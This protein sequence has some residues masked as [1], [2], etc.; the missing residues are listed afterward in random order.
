MNAV[1][2][3]LLDNPVL[4]LLKKLWRYS[5][6]H[7]KTVV[8]YFF[9]FVLGNLVILL[10]PI[11]VAKILNTIQEQGVNA[12]NLSSILGLIA[13]FIAI[14]VAFWVFHGPARVMETQ[15]AFHVRAA[16]KQYLL[17][18]VMRLPSSWHTD[19][20]SGDT[21]DKVE[22]GSRA[23][24][25]FTESTF[26]VTESLVRFFGA[27]IALVYFNI[28]SSYLVAF[29][30]IVTIT[31]ILGFDKK[32]ER[33]YK[34]LNKYENS[35]AEK[36]YDTI[37]NITTVIILRIERLVSSAVYKRIMKPWPLFSKNVRINEWKWFIVS[38]CSASTM[39]LVIGSYIGTTVWQGGVVLFGT[40]YVLYGYIYKI[41]ETFYRFAYLYGRIVRYK[42]NVL[43][44]EELAKEFPQ[45][46]AQEQTHLRNGWK[47][48]EVRNLQFS[49]HEKNEAGA[50]YDLHVDDVNFSFAHGERIAFIG[51]SGSG[52]TTTLKIMRGL[53]VPQ[54]VEVVVDGV[55]LERGFHS[56]SADMALV[57]QDPEI[58]NATVEDNITVGVEHTEEEIREYTDLSRFTS[59]VERLPNGLQSSI[60]EKGVNLSGGEKQRLAL[61]RG[62]LAS[63]DKSIILLD[64]PT[65]SVDPKNELHIYENIFK[66]FPDKSIISSVHRLHLLPL[67]DQVVIFEDG[68]IVEQGSFNG[69]L[70]KSNR[71]KA[72]WNKY[73]HTTKGSKK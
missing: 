16:Y 6:G 19:H 60:V 12:D 15:T 48:I 56:M 37:S 53:Y 57:P 58:F 52:K 22:K 44:A 72:L 64:E 42:A 46:L 50:E 51:E 21:I 70:K 36:I 7:R 49:Y 18:G 3:F 11:L 32:L 30:V 29:L 8:L 38:V 69:L 27:Y 33:Q 4:Y 71:F 39:F 59:V 65:S 25:E 68:T 17:D 28:H 2:T 13:L 41:Q 40:V 62:L 31:I 26:E 47:N 54:H 34:K 43:N 5:A 35:I 20:H 66:R 9:L 63:A 14:D 55:T 67:F 23:L 10:E 73:Q 1:K 61:A 24:F 45:E